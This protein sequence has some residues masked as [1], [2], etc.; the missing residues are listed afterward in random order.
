MNWNASALP[1]EKRL[2][3]DLAFKV[4]RHAISFC[5]AFRGGALLKRA[6]LLAQDVHRLVDRRFGHFGRYALDGDGRQIADLDFR[7]NLEGGVERHLPLGRL[8]LLRDLGHAGHTQLGLVGSAVEGLADLV[9]HDLVLHRV[10]ITLG[11][12]AHRHLAGAKAVGLDRARQLLQPGFDFTADARDRQ[13]QRDAA[14]QLFEGFNLDR[15]GS[16]LGGVRRM[17]GARGGTRTPTPVRA[18][19]PKPGAST[20]F[21]TRAVWWR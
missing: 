17:R 10:A 6:A 20:N 8:V 4:D 15:H 12:D 5:C 18:S 21:A 13:G 19:G 1:P 14:L 3:V 16:A 11:D 7:I 9:V 2:A